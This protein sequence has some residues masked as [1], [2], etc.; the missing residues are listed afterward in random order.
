MYKLTA[1]KKN[2]TKQL[3][4]ES[5]IDALDSTLP[6]SRLFREQCSF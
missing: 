1:F 2:A 3:S 6:A 5:G 4:K